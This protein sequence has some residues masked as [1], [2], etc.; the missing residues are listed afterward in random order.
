MLV[1]LLMCMYT[2]VFGVVRHEKCV[3]SGHD[4]VEEVL[5]CGDVG[6]RSANVSR[7]LNRFWQRCA[8]TVDW[9]A[10][11]WLIKRTVSVPNVMCGGFGE[12]AELVGLNPGCGV[13]TGAQLF[14]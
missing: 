14:V 4:A 7:K 6:G 1:M 8:C 10:A 11:C 12:A 2:K 13:R 3:E 5:C 9:A